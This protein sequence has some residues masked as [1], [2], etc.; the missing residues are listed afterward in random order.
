[1]FKIFALSCF[2]LLSHLP[3]SQGSPSPRTP[4][5]VGSALLPRTTP[6]FPD[7]P[8]SCP[9]CAQNY[10]SI[11]SCAQACPVFQ[12]F[13]SVIFNPGPFIDTIKCACTDTFQ[14]A[15]P[16]CVDCFGRTNQTGWLETDNLPAV[17]QGIR[18][19]CAIAST[20]IGQAASAD[21]E[22]PTTT[23]APAP[24]VASM[25]DRTFYRANSLGVVWI[26]TFVAIC[27]G[28]LIAF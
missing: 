15:F 1:M 19:V 28:G 14:A 24:T 2:V 13:S 4:A 21:G 5:R 25:G 22:V 8:P 11:N 27:S 6:Y 12:N 26:A 10:D 7:T 9:I 16:Q 23:A 20:L 17:V 3:S 18:N